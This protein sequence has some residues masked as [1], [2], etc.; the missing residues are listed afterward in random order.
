MIVAERLVG[1]V[2]SLVE[3]GV[4]DRGGRE[5]LVVVLEGGAADRVPAYRT[6]AFSAFLS[7]FVVREGAASTLN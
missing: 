6:E 3:A 2:F 1:I 4:L 7:Q 5:M